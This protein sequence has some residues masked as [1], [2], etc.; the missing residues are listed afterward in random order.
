ML[1][2]ISASETAATS[3]ATAAE[4]SGG[5]TEEA[6]AAA[7]AGNTRAGAAWF[8]LRRPGSEGGEVVVGYAAAVAGNTRAGAAWFSLRRPG[9]EGGEVVVVSEKAASVA[10]KETIRAV[11]S[12]GAQ[13]SCLKRSSLLSL[14]IPQPHPKIIERECAGCLFT[15]IAASA[16]ER[17]SS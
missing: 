11:R 10:A 1:A 16:A 14:T 12:A 3:A 15:S 2:E 8:P 17:S 4:L 9:S 6:D 13:C 7:A 5:R